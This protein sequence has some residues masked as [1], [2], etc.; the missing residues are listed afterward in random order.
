M[1]VPISVS[2]NPSEEQ[3]SASLYR[4]CGIGN[5]DAFARQSLPDL[6]AA[7]CCSTT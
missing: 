5:K 6:G 7:C 1:E 4:T 3:S 2:L